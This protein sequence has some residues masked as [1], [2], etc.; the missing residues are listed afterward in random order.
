MSYFSSTTFSL[1][2]SGFCYSAG[3]CCSMHAQYE[4]VQLFKHILLMLPFLNFMCVRMEKFC[5]RLG[6][7]TLWH[8]SPSVSS[9]GRSHPQITRQCC[10][11]RAS[12]WCPCHLCLSAAK[13]LC[14]VSEDY[15]EYS[16]QLWNTH[17]PTL[18][19]GLFRIWA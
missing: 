15:A 2:V 1:K 5:P 11:V 9:T 13:S 3:Y 6:K 19:N 14:S 18:S 17:T 10:A 8:R 7:R 16:A 4:T 12:I